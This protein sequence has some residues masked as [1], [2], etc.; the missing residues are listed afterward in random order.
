[1]NHLHSEVT[2]G[3]GQA[4]I[5]HLDQR[6][7]V[8]VMDAA[9]YERYRRDGSHEYFGGSATRSPAVIRPPHA[10]R[11]H[12]AIDLGGAGGSVRASVRTA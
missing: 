3:P 9:N 11:W 5:V 4:V 6:A 2:L 12:V 8:K 10:G 1:M 7:N